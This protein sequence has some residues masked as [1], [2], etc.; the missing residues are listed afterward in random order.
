MEGNDECPKGYL[1]ISLWVN[2]V[3]SRRRVLVDP[4]YIIAS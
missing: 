3:P 2:A 1:V 4:A